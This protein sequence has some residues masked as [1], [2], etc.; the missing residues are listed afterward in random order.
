MG[1]DTAGHYAR[2]DIFDV[3]I[4]RSRRRMVNDDE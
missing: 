3:R 4:D 1:L 2:P